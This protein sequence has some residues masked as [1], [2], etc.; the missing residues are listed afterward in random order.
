MDKSCAKI[1]LSNHTIVELKQK[2]ANVEQLKREAEEILSQ[3]SAPSITP[4]GPLSPGGASYGDF[5]LAAPTVFTANMFQMLSLTGRLS[6]ASLRNLT[7]QTRLVTTLMIAWRLRST[8][9]SRSAGKFCAA[10]LGARRRRSNLRQ[11][12]SPSPSH[13]LR[14]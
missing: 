12:S 7:P 8:A 10:L 13:F 3:H 9:Y 6:V 1:L 14:L 5:P 2:L 4:T 11:S